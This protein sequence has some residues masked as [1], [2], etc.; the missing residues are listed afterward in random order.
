MVTEKERADKALEE[1][2]DAH[3][4][5]DK[6]RADYERLDQTA[7]DDFDKLTAV[8]AR[9]QKLKDEIDGT[10]PL[11]EAAGLLVRASKLKILLTS[12][13]PKEAAEHAGQG[14]ES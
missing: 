9:E 13:Y 5:I 1:L 8:E 6:L 11:L 14:Y 10:I 2:D 12:L 4:E 3:K 7:A